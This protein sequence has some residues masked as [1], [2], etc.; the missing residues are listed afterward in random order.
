MIGQARS[1]PHTAFSLAALID[2][3]LPSRRH[4]CKRLKYQA[5]PSA[6]PC[7]SGVVLYRSLK[8]CKAESFIKVEKA[9][10]PTTRLD[11]TVSFSIPAGFEHASTRAPGKPRSQLAKRVAFL[12]LLQGFETLDQAVQGLVERLIRRPV[13]RQ[14]AREIAWKRSLP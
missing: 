6:R 7:R 1:R 13:G 11:K 5:F 3:R 12:V 2:D 14:P 9:L 10:K 8:P 4:N